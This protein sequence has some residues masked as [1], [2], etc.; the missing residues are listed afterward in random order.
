MLINQASD[1][2]YTVDKFIFKEE[3]EDQA[4]KVS[5]RT[6]WVLV[7]GNPI[8]ITLGAF[9]K[10]QDWPFSQLLL[11]AGLIF[12]F[13]A[14]SIILSGMVKNQLY[15]KDFWGLSMFVIPVLT[16]FFYMLQRKRLRRL[17]NR[18]G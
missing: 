11:T 2:T 14:C 17:V 6:V 13:P 10:V 5:L 18:F 15:N 7:I 1:R 9:A 16:P 3:M 4:F 8:M 12:F